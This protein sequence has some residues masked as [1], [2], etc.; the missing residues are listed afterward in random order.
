M[1]LFLWRQTRNPVCVYKCLRPVDGSKDLLVCYYGVG[2]SNLLISFLFLWVKKANHL[3][4][5]C[6]VVKPVLFSSCPDLWVGGHSLSAGGLSSADLFLFSS[7]AKRGS[8]SRCKVGMGWSRAVPELV[9][10]EGNW[11]SAYFSKSYDYD[12]DLLTPPFEPLHKNQ[13]SRNRN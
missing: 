4:T 5:E 13:F 10:R 3:K 7:T 2:S 8:G 12:S 6:A 9:Y 1:T 11:V